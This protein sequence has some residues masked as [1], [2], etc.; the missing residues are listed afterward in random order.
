MTWQHIHCDF[1]EAEKRIDKLVSEKKKAIPATIK[2]RRVDIDRCIKEMQQ[3]AD[4]MGPS[5]IWQESLAWQDIHTAIMKLK[6]AKM[7]C[8][9][10][11]GELGSQLPEEYRDEAK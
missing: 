9:H 8:G 5:S 1:T 10:A 4:V 7:W 6:E 11:L 2:A 3:L